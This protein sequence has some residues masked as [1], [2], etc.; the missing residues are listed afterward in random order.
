MLMINVRITDPLGREVDTFAVDHDLPEER[1][2][3]GETC[4]KQFEAGNK[5]ET[6]PVTP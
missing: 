2:L 6:W 4:R 1:R 3:L 5:V